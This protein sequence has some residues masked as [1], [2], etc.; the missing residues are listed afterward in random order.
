MTDPLAERMRRHSSYNYAFNNL[1][2][3]VD[4]GGMAS[5]DDYKLLKNGDVKIVA[6]RIIITNPETIE[7]S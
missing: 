2:R 3:F 7:Y 6:R 5:T 4:P 1:V